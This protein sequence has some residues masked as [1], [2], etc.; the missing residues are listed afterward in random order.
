MSNRGHIEDTY[1]VGVLSAGDM[2]RFERVLTFD[3]VGFAMSL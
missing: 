3:C 2:H 1:A